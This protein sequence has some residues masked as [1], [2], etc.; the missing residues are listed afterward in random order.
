[1]VGRPCPYAFHLYNRTM[2]KTI[3][4]TRNFTVKVPTTPHVP[5]EDGGHIFVEVNDHSI[6]ERAELSPELT[7][8]LAWLISL[9]GQAYWDIMPAR[10]LDLYR[11]NYQDNGNW[12]FVRGETP[13]L[14]VHLYGRTRDE[15]HQTYGQALHFPYVD[16]GFYDGFEALTDDDIQALADRMARLATTEKFQDPR[17]LP[18]L[19]E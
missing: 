2:D 3:Y 5:R 10:G 15:S 18:Q 13:V 6:A 16:T 8:E 17:W 1:M 11:L 4:R 12:A 7:I 9:A 19:P 14:H